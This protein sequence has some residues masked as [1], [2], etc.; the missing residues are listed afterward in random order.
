[1]RLVGR[2]HRP[3]HQPSCP[4]F[5]RGSRAAPWLRLHSSGKRP[6]V[7]PPFVATVARS[8][9]AGGIMELHALRASANVLSAPPDCVARRRRR[10]CAGDGVDPRIGRRG[11]RGMVRCPDT[12]RG[13]RGAAG[14]GSTLAGPRTRCPCVRDG[15]RPSCRCPGDCGRVGARR[16]C[17]PAPGWLACPDALCAASATVP[18]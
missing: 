11:R 3:G 12:P 13:G 18:A 2:A 17:V 8:L 15:L 9:P 5:P 10:R 6:P 16:G 4:D 1:V 14:A 7:L